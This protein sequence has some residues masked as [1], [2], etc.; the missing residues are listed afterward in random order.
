[1]IQQSVCKFVLPG[2]GQQMQH[3]R[4]RWWKRWRGALDRA[5]ER[6]KKSPT[7]TISCYLILVGYVLT[8]QSVTSNL[9][10]VYLF[11]WEWITG[12]ICWCPRKNEESSKETTADLRKAAT[13]GRCY[14]E[15]CSLN[16]T[17]GW[18]LCRLYFDRLVILSLD[19]RRRRTIGPLDHMTRKD[20]SGASENEPLV[21]LIHH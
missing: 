7:Y 3:S 19:R 4:R 9:C 16:V 20:A 5:K 21:T 17:S 11:R 12:G 14:C 2:D 15:R 6:E 8:Y 10:D 1:M 13:S 18:L